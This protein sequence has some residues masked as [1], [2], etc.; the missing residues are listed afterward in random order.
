MHRKKKT[1]KVLILAGLSD[2]KLQSK[3][4]PILNNP[5][6]TRIFL[7]RKT[8]LVT[9]SPK[10]IN[11]CTPIFLRRYTPMVEFYRFVTALKICFLHR[12]AFVIG[13]YFFMHGFYSILLG[14]IT[15][16][17]SVVLF[18]GTDLFW[19]IARS[20]HKTKW[21]KI[22]S[23]AD[24]IGVR[25]ENG[26]SWLVDEGVPAEKIF[27]PANVYDFSKIPSLPRQEKY[28]FVCVAG[29]N[30]EKRL[31]ILLEALSYVQKQTSG[32]VTLA[33]VGD[34]PKRPELEEQTKALGLQ[35]NVIF[36]GYQ[37]DIFSWLAQSRIFIMTSRQEGLPVAL[38][39]ALSVGL[40]AIVP[41]IG[42]IS[43][44][45]QNKKNSLLV[46]ALDVTGFA[47]AMIKLLHDEKLY[48]KL[49]Q[50]AY[51]IRQE[52]AQEYSPEYIAKQW[53]Q[54]FEKAGF[55]CRNT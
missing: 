51:Q 41:D 9:S 14:K 45:A 55:K 46:P 4:Q 26:K 33:L 13:F 3:I 6:I 49:S 40:P 17:K 35:E 23:Q 24:F 1:M 32:K 31:D 36:A 52:K 27:I 54:I 12:P 29:L 50:K 34:G 39:E 20:E 25:G 2:A 37:K 22:I 48:A 43:T 18:L 19:N 16:I 15:G 28:D 44:L 42:D 8:P 30:Q 38:I 10:L 11:Y 7:V 5:K 47:E 53:E 21:S